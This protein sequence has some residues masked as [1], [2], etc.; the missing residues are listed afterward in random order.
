M[1]ASAAWAETAIPS[2]NTAYTIP[3]DG[4]FSVASGVRVEN[5]NNHGHAI[6]NF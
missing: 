1:A 3:A 6:I 5:T 2:T 4:D